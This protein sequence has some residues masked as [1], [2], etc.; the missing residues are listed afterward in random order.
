MSRSHLVLIA[1]ATALVLP[2]SATAQQRPIELGI[3]AFRLDL[4]F[5]GS[6]V[7]TITVPAQSFR[8]GFFVSDNVSMEPRLSVNFLTVDQFST[9]TLDLG[10]GVP[11]HFSP[12]ERTR[13]RGFVRP[14]ASW[15]FVDIDGTSASQAALGVGIGVKI[16]LLTQIAIR[17]EAILTHGFENDDFA[18]TNEIGA[19]FGFSFFTR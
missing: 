17:L 10:F 16:P 3:D 18:S 6:T 8:A 19:S 1:A 9:T 12:D 14:V 13:S 7:T 15:R 2:L 11:I 4:D 5:N